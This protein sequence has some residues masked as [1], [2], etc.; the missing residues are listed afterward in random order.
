MPGLMLVGFGAGL[1]FVAITRA[2]LAHVDE[3]AAGLA[4]GPLS[5]SVQIGPSLSVAVLVAVSSGRT[6]DLAAAG[7]SPVTAQLGGLQLRS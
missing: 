1:S 5:T 4:S 3:A 2:A 7:A 6:A